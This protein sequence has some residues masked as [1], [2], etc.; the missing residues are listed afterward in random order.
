MAE[1]NRRVE[2]PAGGRKNGSEVPALFGWV[3][4]KVA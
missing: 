2:K 3:G 1:E 4:R